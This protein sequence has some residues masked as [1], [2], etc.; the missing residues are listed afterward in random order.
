MKT[1]SPAFVNELID[2][3]PT[4]ETREMGFA[5]AQRDG[6]VALFNM[7]QRNKVAYLADE[8]G[9]GKTY[10][11]L[12]VMALARYF[13]PHARIVVIA[14][15]ENIQRKWVKELKNFVR[16]N[17]RIVGNRVKSLQGEPAWEP[18]HCDTL[19]DFVREA[20][21]NADRDFF[22]RMTSFS[23]ALKQAESRRR[24]RRRL[25]KELRWVNRR[26][27][28]AKTPDGFRDAFGTALNA[29]FPDAGCFRHQVLVKRA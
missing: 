3:A 20:M 15:R 7:L 1:V 24:L 14:P 12:G 25:F 11:A 28:A 27:L 22:L 17:W 4:E 10:V 18:V 16:H 26:A 29:G 2:F 21:L 13:D 6:T 23:L 9:M 5:D 8:V 19:I